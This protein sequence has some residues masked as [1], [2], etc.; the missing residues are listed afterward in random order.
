MSIGE[1]CL[2]DDILKRYKFKSFSTPYSSG[3]TNIDY[4]IQLETMDHSYFLN[5][6]YLEY[7]MAYG[8]T[9]VVRSKIITNSSN[10]YANGHMDGFELTHNDI[11][12]SMKEKNK[13][14]RRIER[15]RY[16]KGKKNIVFFY[17]YR[18]NENMN[19]EKII[20]K[21]E[22]LLNIYNSKQSKS[23]AVIFTQEIIKLMDRKSI[24]FLKAK[25]N[26]LL[27]TFK[28]YEFWGGDDQDIFYARVDEDLI[29]AMMNQVK[30]YVE[31]NI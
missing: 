6:N 29:K 30:E 22:I 13:I 27:F 25:D 14:K 5:N 24:E 16:Y 12:S 10:I 1:N 26:I 28:T 15:M 7:G 21:M 19:L 3:R 20:N 18:Y 17:H 31:K 8:K 9:K 2:T 11:I 4:V 23:L